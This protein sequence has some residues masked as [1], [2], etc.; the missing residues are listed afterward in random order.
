MLMHRLSDVKKCQFLTALHQPALWFSSRFIFSRI[1]KV[2][3]DQ[4]A[5]YDKQPESLD[6]LESLHLTTHNII[7]L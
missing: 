4:S 1:R 2:M 6:K 5:Y 7:G 3:S